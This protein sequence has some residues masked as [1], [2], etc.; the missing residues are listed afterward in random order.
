LNDYHNW[1]ALQS[2]LQ[3]G[4]NTRW[5]ELLEQLKQMIVDGDEYVFTVR[6]VDE[7]FDI[8]RA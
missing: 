1:S 7:Y 3:A 2:W 4:K 8:L 6:G 5:D